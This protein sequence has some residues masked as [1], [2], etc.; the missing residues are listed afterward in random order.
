MHRCHP[1]RVVLLLA[2]SFALA[3]TVGVIAQEGAST[4]APATPRPSG[5]RV[6]IGGRALFISCTGK[7]SPTVVLEAGGGNAAD[8]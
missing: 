6:D 4:A 7:G 2:A 1:W 5:N 3:L 8:T